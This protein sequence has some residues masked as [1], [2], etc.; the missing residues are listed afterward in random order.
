MV[1]TQFQILLI[2]LIIREAN[3]ELI[4]KNKRYRSRISRQVNLNVK[5]WPFRH[6]PISK[7][8]ENP[9]VKDRFE[10][11]AAYANDKNVYMH[12]PVFLNSA[13][14]SCF[15]CNYDEDSPNRLHRHKNL[16]RTK[17]KGVYEN[18]DVGNYHNHNGIGGYIDT[19]SENERKIHKGTN[20]FREQRHYLK[21]LDNL[22]NNKNHEWEYQVYHD[23]TKKYLHNQNLFTV[24]KGAVP[25]LKEKKFLKLNY[26]EDFRKTLDFHLIFYYSRH[27]STIVCVIA[28]IIEIF[29]LALS[30]GHFVVALKNL[31]SSYA[32][33]RILENLD[34]KT[35]STS[36][37]T[38]DSTTTSTT[39]TTVLTTASTTAAT[40]ATTTTV[41]PSVVDP[42]DSITC[43]INGETC[44]NGVCKC[45]TQNSCYANP[46]GAY[47]DVASGMC[48]CTLSVNS[49]LFPE[50]CD[51]NAGICK[52][53]SSSSCFGLSTGSYC[54]SSTRVHVNVQ[55]RSIPVRFQKLVIVAMAYASVE[56]VHHA[57]GC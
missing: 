22:N 25:F 55:Q 5:R 36:T 6:Y 23:I 11:I 43:S 18:N 31:D 29:G 56:P 8:V 19:N 1:L 10:Y 47:C 2:I 7:H 30:S 17:Q 44:S 50:I 52:C 9:F 26:L 13:Q 28:V 41:I 42:C 39:T 12:R 57:A 35:I 32:N 21:H 38:T 49:C 40:T 3:N 16:I 24:R 34:S 48:K 54:D 14:I 4:V 51:A 15:Q 27:L 46:Q 33:K 53:G 20:L 45:G 37:T